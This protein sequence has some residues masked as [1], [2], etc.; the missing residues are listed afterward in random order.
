[1][2]L[3]RPWCA[4]DAAGAAG[5]GAGAA[6]AG[7]VA[8]APP[9]LAPPRTGVWCEAAADAS[10]GEAGGAAE[11]EPCLGEPSAAVG[12]L[13]LVG[14]LRM[15]LERA[16]DFALGD[17]GLARSRGTATPPAAVMDWRARCWVERTCVTLSGS[18]AAFTGL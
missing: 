16:P 15:R 2:A 18:S 1:M 17:D 6:G 4:A 8:F 3:G 9:A 12:L 11:A 5:A 10:G 14:E 13:L 7:A